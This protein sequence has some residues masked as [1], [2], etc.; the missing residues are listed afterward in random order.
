MLQNPIY[1]GEIVHKD[2][3]YPGEHTAI[4][5]PALWD[6]VKARLA[7]NAVDRSTGIRVKN[8]ILLALV[9]RVVMRPDEV[10][11]HLRPCRLAALLDDRLT[12]A[13][14]APLNDEPTQ[15]LSQPVRLR[16]AG[17]EVRMVIDHTDPF[18]PPQKSDRRLIKAIGRAHRFHDMLVKHKSGKFADLAKG[19]RLHRSYFTQVLRLA[20]LA[21]DITTAILDGRQPEGL[22]AT[23]LV[24]WSS[25]PLNW[26]EQRTA[27]GFA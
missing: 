10:I 1:R 18:A 2:E 25:L 17:K 8:P 7:E 16:R 27:L 23:M 15:S 3:T 22:T 9:Q 14:P 4:I 26:G 21:P 24:E 11:I 13:N 12:T 20:Y 5:D 19:E 6:A